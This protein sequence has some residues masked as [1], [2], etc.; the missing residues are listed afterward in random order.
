MKRSIILILSGLIVL[1]LILGLLWKNITGR[2]ETNP[3]EV[4]KER[5]GHQESTSKELSPLELRLFVNDLEEI[6]ITP[7]TPLIFSLTIRNKNAILASYDRMTLKRFKEELDEDV[8]AKTMTQKQADWMINREKLPGQVLPIEILL[9]VE[10]FSFAREGTKGDQSLPWEPKVLEPRAPVQLILDDKNA[11]EMMF[12]VPPEATT[13][14]TEGTYRVVAIFRDK[15]AKPEQWTGEIVSNPVVITVGKEAETSEDKTQRQ[16]ALAEYFV[17]VKDYDNAEKAIKE[18]LSA[19]PDSIRGLSLRGQVYE[20]KGDYRAALESYGK[21]L[22]EFL[23]LCPG[24]E[25]PSALVERV[26][27]M[28]DKLGIKIPEV[29]E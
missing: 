19:Y 26:S 4:A 16:M 21:A 13:L 15:T 18:V 3:I 5:D 1:T 17:W 12:A 20:R 23:H 6:T 29:V 14:K 25:P 24:H 10:S 27:R 22:G 11:T 7:G 9:K 2:R 28:W 8:R